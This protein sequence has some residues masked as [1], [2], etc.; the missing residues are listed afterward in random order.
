MD[1]GSTDFEV[2]AALEGQ[3]EGPISLIFQKEVSG[4][5]LR[6]RA[7]KNEPPESSGYNLG[8]NLTPTRRNASFLTSSGSVVWVRTGLSVSPR[9]IRMVVRRSLLDKLQGVRRTALR[10]AR[11]QAK[12]SFLYRV[13]EPDPVQKEALRLAGVKL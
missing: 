2:H 5:R 9:R 6:I 13:T 1:D 7:L 12:G 3:V 4:F 11:G 8:Y 10:V